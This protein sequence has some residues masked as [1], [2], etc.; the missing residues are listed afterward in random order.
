MF[1]NIVR[2][3]KYFKFTQKW[4]G[5]TQPWRDNKYLNDLKA[6]LD[7]FT[8]TELSELYNEHTRISSGYTCITE[9]LA[10]CAKARE[11]IMKNRY[12]PGPNTVFQKTSL[13]DYLITDDNYRVGFVSGIYTTIEEMVRLQGVINDVPKE[14]SRDY[15]FNQLSDLFNTGDA[16][17]SIVLLE[18]FS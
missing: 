14:V 11:A 6:L 16:F 7:T 9:W 10:A 8:D 15:Y 5:V 3:Y 18:G 4:K 1:T 17:V 13:S 2:R 12:R